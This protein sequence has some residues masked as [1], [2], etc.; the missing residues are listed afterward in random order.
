MQGNGDQLDRVLDPA[1]A[2]YADPGPD[3]GLE[4]RILKRLAEEGARAPHRRWLAWAIALP[5]VAGV[6]LLAVLFRPGAHPV[7]A[8]QQAQVSRRTAPKS[9]PTNRLVLGSAPVHRGRIPLRARRPHAQ[10]LEASSAPLPKLDVFPT[11]EPVTPAEGALAR[12]VARMPRA[13]QQALAESQEQQFPLTAATIPTL[14]LASPDAE[15]LGPPSD[16]GNL[17]LHSA[18]LAMFHAKLLVPISE[19]SN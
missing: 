9:R 2:T 15:A 7:S 1:L 11:P 17:T 8:P 14:L 13:Q 4:A 3:S 10:V 16:G 19:D 18:P 6:L 12:C 5:A